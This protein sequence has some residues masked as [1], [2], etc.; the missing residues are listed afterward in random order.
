LFLGRLE[1]CHCLVVSSSTPCL[2]GMI[3]GKPVPIF[4]D[5]ALMNG[6]SVSVA[7]LA[8]RN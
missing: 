1:H 4:P 8:A 7:K 5:H 2:L 3:F 6:S